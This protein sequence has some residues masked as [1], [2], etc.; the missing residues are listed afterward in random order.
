MNGPRTARSFFVA[1]LLLMVVAYYAILHLSKGR[2]A[3]SSS[4][5]AIAF[6]L[7]YLAVVVMGF[8]TLRAIYIL[9]DFVPRT[10]CAPA[11]LRGAFEKIRGT[12]VARAQFEGPDGRP[13]VAA[14]R[15]YYPLAEQ[16]RWVPFVLEVDGEEFRV[17]PT[18][19]E[20]VIKEASATTWKAIAARP[21]SFA[22]GAWAPELVDETRLDWVCVRPGDFVEL[23]GALHWAV[24]PSRTDASAFR[25]ATDGQ[26]AT[27]PYRTAHEAVIDLRRVVD[28]TEGSS[29]SLEPLGLG[30]RSPLAVSASRWRRVAS[31]RA[32][33]RMAS[34]VASTKPI[35][36]VA[37]SS[38]TSAVAT[39]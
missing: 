16:S 29:M 23:T 25:L 19:P 35:S 36:S 5:D 15:T 34:P 18:E 30:H 24:A 32:S 8:V 31:R 37:L 11:E 21:R 13:C 7:T 38:T 33:G 2:A 14:V 3:A 4:L 20:A 1:Q 26:S 22:R 39:S 10:P 12:V 28:A 6:V 17:E 9:P 27:S